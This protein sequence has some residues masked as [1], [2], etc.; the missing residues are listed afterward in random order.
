MGFLL[1]NM[2]FAALVWMLAGG[3]MP[4]RIYTLVALT[5]ARFISANFNYLCNRFVVFRPKTAKNGPHR[6]YFSY[7]GL[8]L[9]IGGASYVFTEALGEMLGI[10]GV[11]ITAVKIFV[12]TILFFLGYFIQKRFVFRNHS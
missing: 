1:D 2:V 3:G 10:D 7:W 4:R 9:V 11:V 5:V 8:V 6:S 12:D